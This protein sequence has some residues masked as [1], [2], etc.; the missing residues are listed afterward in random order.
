MI[1]WFWLLVIGWPIVGQLGR[2]HCKFRVK[3]TSLQVLFELFLCWDVWGINSFWGSRRHSWLGSPLRPFD[4]CHQYQ[5]LRHS[6]GPTRW[7]FGQILKC[8][9]CWG[10]RLA[11]WLL[12]EKND[13]LGD[14]KRVAFFSSL[15]FTHTHLNAWHTHTHRHS[16]THAFTHTLTRMTHTHTHSH[17]RFYFTYEKDN[18]WWSHSAS[19]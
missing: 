7:I 13:S 15:S 9:E 17:T 1:I 10:G 14:K 19:W 8:F 3:L 5:E 16:H 4:R 18:K 6:N 12:S 2:G 11:L